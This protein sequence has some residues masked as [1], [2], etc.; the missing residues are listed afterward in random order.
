MPYSK[1]LWCPK[2]IGLASRPLSP[3]GRESVLVYNR[4]SKRWISPLL[5]DLP[6]LD[7]FLEGIT[8]AYW[9][10]PS[11]YCVQLHLRSY[12]CE[13]LINW[14]HIEVMTFNHSHVHLQNYLFVSGITLSFAKQWISRTWSSEIWC[15]VVWYVSTSISEQ[16]ALSNFNLQVAAAGPLKHWYTSS[17]NMAWYPTHCNTFQNTTIAKWCHHTKTWSTLAKNNCE[18][19]NILPA[20]CQHTVTISTVPFKSK[21]TETKWIMIF[22]EEVLLKY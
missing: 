14:M 6:S 11:Y 21:R 17:K 15:H 16:P 1:K 3:E 2:F 8:P 4:T 20:Y 22:C 18:S 10:C 7:T 9:I 5:S 19:T 12:N 13:N